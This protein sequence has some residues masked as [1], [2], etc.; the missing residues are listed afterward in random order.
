MVCLVIKLITEMGIIG[1]SNIS[2]MESYIGVIDSSRF[3][4]IHSYHVGIEGWHIRI[5]NRTTTF[6][7][8]Q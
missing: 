1:S 4:L 6:A 8:I 2:N 3:D 7:T 5:W